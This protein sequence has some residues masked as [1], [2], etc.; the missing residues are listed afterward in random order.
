MTPERKEAKEKKIQF[1]LEQY[2]QGAKVKDICRACNIAATTLYRFIRDS[3][4]ET[5]KPSGPNEYKQAAAQ[6]RWDKKKSKEEKALAKV[7]TSLSTLDVLA[8][9]KLSL[10]KDNLGNYLFRGDEEKKVYLT[11]QEFD[12]LCKKPVELLKSIA[13]RINA[14]VN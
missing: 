9:I 11:N 3:E 7:S 6:R 2:N 10:G 13:A 4:T 5:R 1:A 12:K 14:G 8:R